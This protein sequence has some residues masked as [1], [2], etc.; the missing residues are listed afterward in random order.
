MKFER[1][2][3]LTDLNENVCEIFLTQ[4]GQ[5]RAMRC[6]LK[7][8]VLPASYAT[9]APKVK[10]FHEQNPDFLAVWDMN[11]G[12]WRKLHIDTV[13]YVQVIDTI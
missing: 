4:N 7:P 10:E 13:E 12:G 5:Q 3:L 8:D 2:V 11:N 9:E 6:S 1:D